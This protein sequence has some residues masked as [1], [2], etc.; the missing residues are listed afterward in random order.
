MAFG[1]THQFGLG[2]PPYFLKY[3]IA[4]LWIYYG[5]SKAVVN[6]KILLHVSR[7]FAK[8]VYLCLIAT[9]FFWIIEVPPRWDWGFFGRFLSNSLVLLITIA[10]SISATLTFKAKAIDYSFY[11]LCISLLACVLNSVITF[12]LP[13]FLYVVF[14][15]MQY[16]NEELWGTQYHEVGQYLEVHDATFA[17]GFYFLYYWLFDKRVFKEKKW[18][19]F[20]C[21]IGMYLGFKRLQIGA[22]IVTYLFYKI[23][24]DHKKMSLTK[25]T[26][27][28]LYLTFFTS[29]IYVALIKY[30]PV[31]FLFLDESRVNLYSFLGDMVSFNPLDIGKGFAYVNDYLGHYGSTLDYGKYNQGLLPVSHSE[32]TRMYIELGIVCFFIWLKML[33]KSIPNSIYSFGGTLCVNIYMVMLAY[34]LFTY[35]IDNTMTLF[36]TQFAFYMISSHFPTMMYVDKMN[37]KKSL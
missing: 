15:M 17:F 36:A 18:H 32:L 1:F 23:I 11:A 22:I 26:N 25:K 31:L 20:L 21:I 4:L 8:P 37:Y 10:A 24:V 33:C 35:L 6:K 2:Q 13:S 7:Q 19:L 3:I 12:G 30:V 29:I 34:L 9:I 16:V 5:L 28:V 14:H 27:I